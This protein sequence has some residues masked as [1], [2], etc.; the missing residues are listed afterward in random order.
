M[1][2]WVTAHRLNEV[3]DLLG[4]GI[5][6]LG[7][8][9]TLWAVFSSRSAARAAETAAKQARSEMLR[10][11]VIGQLTEALL[12]IEEFKHLHRSSAWELMPQRYSRLRIDLVGIRASNPHLG[13]GSKVILQTAIQD[14]RVMEVRVDRS[15]VKGADPPDIARMNKL[16][17]LLT[18]MKINNR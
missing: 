10:I 4:L 17:E 8:S 16:Q 1:I 11:D 3:S 9:L 14:L 15:L 12:N 5:A 6:I 18:D 2:D 7:F 13:E